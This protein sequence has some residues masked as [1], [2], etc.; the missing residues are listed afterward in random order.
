MDTL[1]D[2]LREQAQRHPQRCFVRSAD[3][4][5]SYQEFVSAVSRC[6]TG[7]DLIGVREGDRVAVMLR[8]HFEHLVLVYALKRVNAVHVPVSIHLKSAGVEL[9]LDDVRPHLLFAE[10]EF[11]DVVRAASQRSRVR[12]RQVWRRPSEELLREG[13]DL[14]AVLDCGRPT[15]DTVWYDLDRLDQVSYT[16]GTTGAPK[17]A[18]LTDRYLQLGARSARDLASIGPADNLLLWE[19]LYHGGGWTAIYAAILA[20]ASVSMVEKFSASRCWDQTR[21]FGCTRL[22]YLGAVVNLLLKQQPRDDDA[23][24]PVEIA[25]GAAC[26]QDSWVR[27]EERFG[28]EVR[29]GYGLTEGADFA[30]LNIDGPVGS[31]GR[32]IPE[33][34]AW[35]ESQPGVRAPQ[36]SP[37]EL[38]LRPHA[39]KL[40]MAGFF[41]NGEASERVLSGGL[42]RTGDLAVELEDGYF[43]FQGRVT[44]SLRRRGENVSA[45]EV[46]R[47]AEQNPEITE[48]AVIGVP[49]EMGEEDIKIF[50]RREPGSD[51]GPE[52]V[53]E[54]CRERLAYY[55]VPRYVE[56]V[57]D[58]PRGAT[59]RVRKSAL[60]RDVEGVYDAEGAQ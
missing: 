27:F 48:A 41:R 51:I 20:G 6:A 18:K 28:V 44:D 46:E 12:P 34:E 58:F 47:V 37:G 54:W 50:I 24:N 4:E 21:E 49:S 1:I 9:L 33:F 11:A 15:V 45:W 32:P 31:M 13:D 14:G 7:L 43:G 55:Q 30:L 2:A 56:F 35:V 22:H 36:G 3:G 19:P 38:V 25:W 29:E 57:E 42:V 53:L 8:N 59:Q 5:L 23:D 39:E 16:S 60:S 52:A 10:A 17:G 40:T 26:P